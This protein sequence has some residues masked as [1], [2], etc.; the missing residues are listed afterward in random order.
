MAD[1]RGGAIAP[2]KDR[3]KKKLG[4]QN[5]KQLLKHFLLQNVVSFAPRTPAE[6]HFAFITSSRNSKHGQF[7][8]QT[9]AEKQL[10][11]KTFQS[12]LRSGCLVVAETS[13]GKMSLLI[14]PLAVA[15]LLFWSQNHSVKKRKLSASGG[16]NSNHRLLPH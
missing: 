15:P 1:L 10:S 2:P 7:G 11:I 14:P 3:P 4:T 6:L 8:L 5:V 16:E 13:M 9:Q 12:S